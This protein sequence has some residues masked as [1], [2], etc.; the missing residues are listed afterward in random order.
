MS[1]ASFWGPNQPFNVPTVACALRLGADRRFGKVGGLV[2]VFTFWGF[3]CRLPD[4][5]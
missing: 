5:T 4:S 3:A 1:H 2:L